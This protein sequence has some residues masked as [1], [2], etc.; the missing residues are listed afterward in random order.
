MTRKSWIFLAGVFLWLGSTLVFPTHQAFSIRSSEDVLLF[1][2][3]V[4]QL[5]SRYCERYWYMPCLAMSF[6]LLAQTWPYFTVTPHH[7]SILSASLN[8]QYIAAIKWRLIWLKSM[9]WGYVLWGDF[10]K[11]R[12]RECLMNS[13]TQSPTVDTKACLSHF[14]WKDPKEILSVRSPV[15]RHYNGLQPTPFSIHTS[16]PEQNSHKKFAH[17]KD[18]RERLWCPLPFSRRRSSQFLSKE[19]SI[20]TSTPE[21]NSHISFGHSANENHL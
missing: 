14:T 10:M 1:M 7:V 19:H 21:E 20:D 8:A 4:L 18:P 11:W 3:H 2:I 16:T 9:T 17:W 6:L 15:A 5:S 13:R 12:E